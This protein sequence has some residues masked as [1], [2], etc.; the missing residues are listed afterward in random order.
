M[1][2]EERRPTYL[3]RSQSPTYARY[4]QEFWR[5]ERKDAW[6]CNAGK[7]CARFSTPPRW[8]GCGQ[9]AR[10]PRQRDQVWDSSM[11][12]LCMD[13]SAP[14]GRFR[15]TKLG[16]KQAPGAAGGR[17]ILGQVLSEHG[18]APWPTLLSK[19][20]PLRS[21]PRGRSSSP[22]R[23]QAAMS[24]LENAPTPPGSPR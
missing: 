17:P 1:G 16:P 8:G 23:R 4:S 21:P 2:A 3:A 24:V 10:T 5:S 18:V 12:R 15:R 22:S 6:D 11:A 7:R 13:E 14:Q 20:Q 19:Q 9:K